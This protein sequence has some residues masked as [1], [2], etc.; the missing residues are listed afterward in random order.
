MCQGRKAFSIYLSKIIQYYNL[1]N[2][3]LIKI[4][5]QLRTNMPKKSTLTSPRRGTG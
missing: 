3:F 2:Q 1:Y 5:N 4:E